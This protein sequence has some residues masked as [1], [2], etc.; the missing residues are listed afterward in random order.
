MRVER[1]AGSRWNEKYIIIPRRLVCWIECFFFLG[2]FGWAE[3]L[4]GK[5][6]WFGSVEMQWSVHSF[7]NPAS[8]WFCVCLLYSLN[9]EDIQTH[10]DFKPTKESQFS[11]SPTCFKCSMLSEHSIKWHPQS[12]RSTIPSPRGVYLCIQGC[13]QNHSLIHYSLYNR[14]LIFYITVSRKLRF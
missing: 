11:F 3:L 10:S 2:L 14:C 12:C 5:E 1:E 13:V 7:L 4:Y 9:I 8:V 6:M